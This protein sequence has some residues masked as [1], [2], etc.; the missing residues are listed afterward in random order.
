[1]FPVPNWIPI[2]ACSHWLGKG[3]FPLGN[4][5]TG[6]EKSRESSD[7]W[8]ATAGRGGLSDRE[9]DISVISTC[10]FDF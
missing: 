7:R 6:C 10:R 1:M 4:E 3:M 2:D 9:P 5:T 8:V